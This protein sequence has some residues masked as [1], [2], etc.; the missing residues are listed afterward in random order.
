MCE[1]NDIPLELET[2]VTNY[3]GQEY[4]IQENFQFDQQDAVIESLPKDLQKQLRK[5]AN[6]VLFDGVG[7][8][9]YLSKKSMLK[10][11]GLV[12]RKICHPEEIILRK[13]EKSQ[14]MILQ[15]GTLGFA[16]R[17][18]SSQSSLNNKN[19]EELKVEN[20]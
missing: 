19:I 14:F 20:N 12:D 13:G 2:K 7:F 3:I 6:K 4:E 16:C 11:A 5:E 9:S 10:M 8:L 17:T 18:T 15:K 1:E